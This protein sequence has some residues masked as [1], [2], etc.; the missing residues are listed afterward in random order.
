MIRLLF[1][2]LLLSLIACQTSSPSTPSVTVEPSTPTELAAPSIVTQRSISKPDCVVKGHILPAN[3]IHLPEKDRIVSILADSTTFD[4]KF[5][6]SHR[7]ITVHDTKLCEPIIELTLPVN[8]SPDF[9]YYLAPTPTSSESNLVL[10]KGKNTI[11]CL[12]VITKEVLPTLSP[13][14]K[15]TRMAQDAQSGTILQVTQWG[16]Y[17][18]GYAQD[19]GC[20]VFQTQ[21]QQAPKLLLPYSE[22]PISETHFN[23]LFLLTTSSN[24]TQA[25]LPT[26][27]WETNTLS[28]NP[29]FQEV[30]NLSSPIKSALNNQYLV[31]KSSKGKVF[32]VDAKAAKRIDL[33]KEIQSKKVKEIIDWMKKFHTPSNARPH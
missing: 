10:I 18:I 30:L 19:M 8:S 3:Q 16:N 28:I 24:K 5:G 27:D 32:G 22:Y 29:L 9:P 13:K 31:F 20:F 21:E 4:K 26:Y 33:P 15:T 6:D 11:H 14:F 2:T 23:S 17:I 1:G 12:N 7:K 25:I